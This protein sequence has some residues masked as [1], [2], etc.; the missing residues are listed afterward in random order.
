VEISEEALEE[1]HDVEARVKVQDGLLNW[2]YKVRTSTGIGHGHR[3][4][5]ASCLLI[6][7]LCVA[8]STFSTVCYCGIARFTMECR[9]HPINQMTAVP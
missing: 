6:G 1:A 8:L 3:F 2:R 4:I 7:A 5:H 9:M